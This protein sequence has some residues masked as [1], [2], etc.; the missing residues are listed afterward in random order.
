VSISSI[1]STVI[2]SMKL[3]R[4]QGCA[5]KLD[6]RVPPVPFA[7]VTSVLASNP[8]RSSISTRVSAGIF[9]RQ[10]REAGAGRIPS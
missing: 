10:G 2:F 1:W 7:S 3:T 5:E 9:L 6:Y 4:S 8:L